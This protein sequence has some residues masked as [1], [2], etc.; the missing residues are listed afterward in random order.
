[1]MHQVCI[2]WFAPLTL[3]VTKSCATN[4]SKSRNTAEQT[5]SADEEKS[6]LS[7]Q[8]F[9]LNDLTGLFHTKIH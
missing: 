1:M 6:A 4:F 9:A 7:G 2:T 8:C 3:E 5:P